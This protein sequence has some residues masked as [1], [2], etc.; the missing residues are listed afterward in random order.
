MA[1]RLR[2]PEPERRCLSH[3]VVAGERSAA[4]GPVRSR[5]FRPDAH[6]AGSAYQSR[7]KPRGSSTSRT[8]RSTS[9][10]P[11]SSSAVRESARDSGSW[12]RQASY[13]ACRVRSW[14]RASAHRGGRA[15]RS[16]GRWKVRTGSPGVVAVPVSL[17]ALGVR[18]AHE[19]YSTPLHNGVLDGQLGYGSGW[20]WSSFWSHCH[21][22]TRLEPGLTP[23]ASWT[24]PAVDSHIVQVHVPFAVFFLAERARLCV[25]FFRHSL[26]SSS[27]L[28]LPVRRGRNDDPIKG[29]MGASGCGGQGRRP[30]L[31]RSISRPSPPPLQLGESDTPADRR[32]RAP[33]GS[34]GGGRA[35]GLQ[36]VRNRRHSASSRDAQP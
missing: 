5:R 27:A 17:L 18:H 16:L 19:G 15:R 7:P 11:S 23:P 26:G 3:P 24:K 8:S 1:R 2:P 30:G 21:S 31:P 10:T 6:R 12:L 35:G 34:Q 20:S 28:A 14:S 9:Q 33:A 22:S 4:T 36:P 25:A 29:I 32:R 13:S